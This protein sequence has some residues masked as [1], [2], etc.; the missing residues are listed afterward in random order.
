MSLW[1][2]AGKPQ[3]QKPGFQLLLTLTQKP[4]SESE[5]SRVSGGRGFHYFLKYVITE[6]SFS[7]K[8]IFSF[9]ELL[10]LISFFKRGTILP[11]S[12]QSKLVN[13]HSVMMEISY[14]QGIKPSGF[15]HVNC[16]LSA[17]EKDHFRIALDCRCLVDIVQTSKWAFVLWQY[18]K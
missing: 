16:F 12:L 1:N 10:K 2:R 4:S 3:I 11:F 14:N 9:T 17:V 13:Q 6:S 8:R 7:P 15:G 5:C 18:F